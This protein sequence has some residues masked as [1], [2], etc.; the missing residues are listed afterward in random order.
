MLAARTRSRPRLLRVTSWHVRR[1]V[2]IALMLLALVRIVSLVRKPPA[3]LPSQEAIVRRVVDGDTFVLETGERVRMLGV[4]TPETV[5]PDRPVEA[6]GP[7]ASQFAKDLLEGHPVRL[8]YDRERF[9]SYG[10][11]LG[12]VWRGDQFVNAEI[13]RAGLGRADVRRPL[14]ADRKRLL[15]TAEKEA[16]S[17]RRGLWGHLEALPRRNP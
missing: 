9:D 12:Y 13:L 14:R 11:V 15:E 17:A 16:R 3:G 10:R 8:E 6:W 2:L 1:V 4:D 5:H 7:E